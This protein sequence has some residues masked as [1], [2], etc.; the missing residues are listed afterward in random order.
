[1]SENKKPENPP[2]FP[3]P[4]LK[5]T[6]IRYQDPDQEMLFDEEGQAGM[7]LRDYF[8]AKIINAMFSNSGQWHEDPARAAKFSY[9]ISDE[10]LKAREVK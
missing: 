2:A 3:I 1:M 7:T 9:K 10:M 4:S 8:A 6:A 5:Q